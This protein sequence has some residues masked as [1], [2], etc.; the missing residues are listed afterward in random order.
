[1]LHSCPRLPMLIPVQWI[2]V[3]WKGL[4]WTPVWLQWSLLGP[5]PYRFARSFSESNTPHYS[6]LSHH[7]FEICFF[8][9]IRSESLTR[10]AEPA[11]HAAPRRQVMRD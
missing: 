3:K 4:Y 11:S 2:I 6:L 10:H 7:K 9:T 8:F 5:R 1:L